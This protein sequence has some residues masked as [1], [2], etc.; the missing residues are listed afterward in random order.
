M[1]ATLKAYFRSLATADLETLQ[2]A[3]IARLNGSLADSRLTY[4][5]MGGKTFQFNT[6]TQDQ[7]AFY[8]NEITQVLQEKDP[9]TYGKR[10]TKTYA[11][12]SANHAQNL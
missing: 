9:D 7:T 12:F 11:S 4:V 6:L 2:T 5:S 3:A 10:V 1:P 8:L